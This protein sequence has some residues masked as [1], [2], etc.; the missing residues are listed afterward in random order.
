[1]KAIDLIKKSKSIIGFNTSIGE[2]LHIDYVNKEPQE[3]DIVISGKNCTI[4]LEDLKDCIIIGKTIFINN[5][6]AIHIK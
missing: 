1:M 4:F 6:Y 2:S 3:D 5:R